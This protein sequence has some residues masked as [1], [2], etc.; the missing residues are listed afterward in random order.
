VG[1]DTSGRCGANNAVDDSYQN[2]KSAQAR[3]WT[4]VHLLEPDD[5]APERPA[6]R[7]QIRSLLELK[8]LFPQFFKS[9][10]DETPAPA[11]TPSGQGG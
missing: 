7:Y 11:P 3:G 5:P 6:A 2:C 10:G 9:D 8:A 1:F 4:A